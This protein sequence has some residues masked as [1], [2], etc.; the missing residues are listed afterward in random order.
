MP[1]LPI[2]VH[3]SEVPEH[4]FCGYTNGRYWN[5][6]ACPYLALDEFSHVLELLV[7]WGVEKGFTVFAEEH[8]VHVKGPDGDDYKMTANCV[9]TTDGDKWLFDCGG[10]WT[11]IELSEEPDA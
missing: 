2:T 1:L 8:T 11:F 7:A 5:G 10:V 6:F 4:V 3:F 9:A